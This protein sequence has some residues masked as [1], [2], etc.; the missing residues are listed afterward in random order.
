VAVAFGRRDVSVETALPLVVEEGKGGLA[1]R[2]FALALL[3]RL[4]VGTA[5][6]LYSLQHGFD[7][8]YPLAS[9]HDDR[10][11]WYYAL[12]LV[13]G[14]TVLWTPS[15]YP[16]AL[17]ALFFITGPNL[18]AGK[19]LNVLAGA[20]TVYVGVRLVQRLATDRARA[21]LIAGH[22]AGALLTFYPSLLFYSTQLVKDPLLVLA[23]LMALSLGLRF[24]RHP[25][26][27]LVA[28]GA[29]AIGGMFLLRPYAALALAISLLGF[30]LWSRRRWIAPAVVLA[31]VAPVAVGWG[32]FGSA[33]LMRMLNPAFLTSFR[34][35]TYSIGGSAAGI[36]LDFSNP[37]AL[38]TSYTYSFATAMFGPFPWQ[39]GSAVQLVALP[40]ALVLWALFPI[41]I[42]GLWRLLR[43]RLGDEALLLIFSLVLIGAV[44][45]FSDNIGANT[46]LRMLPWVAFFLFASL[47][48]PEIRLPGRYGEP[49]RQSDMPTATR[50]HQDVHDNA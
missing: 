17:A 44:A 19:L 15:S 11:Y 12:Q 20:L 10:T 46:R 40:E 1:L 5:V 27:P 8:F 3:A 6:D 14:Q 33:Y 37:L 9:G 26:F 4:L 48:L 18:V 35:G 47:H 32:V 39:L 50:A 45:L 22:W 16:Y 43:G 41:W 25:Q 42:M 2:W 28:L 36:R 29:V 7:G 49:R 23:G 30:T 38:L 31:A 24:F 34:E 21:G 13:Q